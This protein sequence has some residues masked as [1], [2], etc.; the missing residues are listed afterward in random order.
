M[1]RCLAEVRI[2]GRHLAD[3]THQIGVELRDAR[4]RRTEDYVHHRRTP[5]AGPV[6]QAA[7]VGVDGGR[8]LTRV[9]TAGQGPGVHGHG[10]EEDKVGRL[11]APERPPVP[12]D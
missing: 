5:P 4:D 1:A 8:L 7:A 3:L 12:A 6:P 2:S 9:T 11:H 10:W